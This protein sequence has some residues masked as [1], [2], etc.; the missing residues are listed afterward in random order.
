MFVW[1]DCS[2]NGG[3]G[4]LAESAAATAVSSSSLT[5]QAAFY[6]WKQPQPQTPQVML[7]TG[8]HAVAS[9]GSNAKTAVLR[10]PYIVA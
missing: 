7:G 10:S 2:G 5:T 6:P 3:G 1:A 4:Y 8:G 9:N